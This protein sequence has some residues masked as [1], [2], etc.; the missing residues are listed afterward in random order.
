MRLGAVELRDTGKNA[1]LLSP[2]SDRARPLDFASGNHVSE[3]LSLD[4]SLAESQHAPLALGVIAFAES[5]FF[6]VPAGRN[7]DPHVAG[8][9]KAAPGSMR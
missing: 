6:P 2:R 9:A 1:S 5:S 4:L 8:E 3:T 7:T